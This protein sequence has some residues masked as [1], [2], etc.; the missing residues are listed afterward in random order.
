MILVIRGIAVIKKRGSTLAISYPTKEDRAL[1]VVPI[2]DLELLVIVGYRVRISSGTLLMLARSGVPVVFHSRSVDAMV[3][4]PFTIR[5]ADVRRRQYKLLEDYN[6][7]TS[8][9]KKFIKGKIRG[10]LSVCRYF[11]YK[12]TE[13]SSKATNGLT[14]LKDLERSF[15]EDL[16]LAS[17]VKSV[18]RV[19][20]K[21]SKKLWE[22]LCRFIP[23]HY[24]FTGRD[25]RSKDP[26][27][28]AINYSYAVIYG[29]C[30]H[31]L[32]SAGLDPYA[33]IIHS[34]RPG[35]VA[36]TYDYS[37]MF[38]PLAIHA[39]VTSSRIASLKLGRDG[40]LTKT[41][42]KVLTKSI[43][44]LLKRKPPT[45]RHTVRAQIYFKAWELRNNIVKATKFTPYT[46][47]AK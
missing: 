28:S 1:D 12:E 37:E 47:R 9:S 18:V 46:Y 7:R 13:Q 27:N 39:T 29:L 8:I 5:I 14:Y 36:L 45:R 30:T 44:R 3:F 11:I 6:W 20:A 31:A 43:Y 34:E 21:W 15:M 41:G 32:I 38:K 19:E 22:Y 42:L 10:F 40:Y 33:G 16:R 2:L 4:T 25:P 26:I 23:E 24:E 17:D 35:R